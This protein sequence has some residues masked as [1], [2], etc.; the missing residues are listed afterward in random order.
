MCEEWN[1]P[2]Y[3]RDATSIV[4]NQASMYRHSLP[5]FLGL[6]VFMNGSI[7]CKQIVKKKTKRKKSG[8]KVE[9]IRWPNNWRHLC[10]QTI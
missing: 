1:I 7:L 8:K 3:L 5:F 2:H 6:V 4:T 9:K 10:T